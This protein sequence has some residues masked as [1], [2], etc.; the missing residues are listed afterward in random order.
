MEKR[1][2]VLVK[3]VYVRNAQ[4]YTGASFTDED[5]M[6]GDIYQNCE[7]ERNWK[8]ISGSVLVMDVSAINKDYVYEKIRKVYPNADEIIFEVIECKYHR[9][10]E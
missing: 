2:L 6:Y 5:I 7:L 1:F 8:E 3:D 10:I 4:A 9:F